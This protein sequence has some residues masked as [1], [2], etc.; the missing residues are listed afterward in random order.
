MYDSIL[1]Y[2]GYLIGQ[3]ADGCI[4]KPPIFSCKIDKYMNKKYISKLQFYNLYS[5]NEISVSKFINSKYSYKQYKNYFSLL[6]KNC[7][8]KFSD[9]NVIFSYNNNKNCFFYSDFYQ[10][11]DNYKSNQLFSISIYKYVPG[12]SLKEF[13]NIDKTI[14]LYKNNI[15]DYFKHSIEIFF[16][17]QKSLFILNNN[18]NYLHNDLHYNNII[19]NTTNNNLPVIIDFGR[20][21]Q[22]VKNNDV[23]YNKF[24]EYFNKYKFKPERTWDSFHVRFIFYIFKYESFQK[25]YDNINI[26][27]AENF[28][29]NKII[30][31]FIDIIISYDFEYYKYISDN[32]F[33]FFYIEK[34]YKKFLKQFFYIFT[35]KHKFLYINDVM[36]Y[37]Y[38]N[39]ILD[40]IDIYVVMFSFIDFLLFNYNKFLK[41]KEL[42]FFVDFFIKY[43]FTNIN[44]NFNTKILYIDHYKFFQYV[45]KI[46]KNSQN[47]QNLNSLQYQAFNKQIIAYFKNLNIDFYFFV[48]NDI[49]KIIYDN[50]DKF[51]FMFD[52]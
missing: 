13:F 39:C 50:R 21:F 51:V 33:D 30:D 37:I 4:H 12:F 8:L 6:V 19:I 18:L 23:F 20:S 46:L 3:G 26:L 17:L 28:L 40:S 25:Y 31:D 44:P 11:Y 24:V 22:V 35:D 9:L 49:F 5:K 36:L 15:F 48:Y 7:L 16:Y 43:L 42:S 45:Y 38:N 27:D 41:E 32:K 47:S 14:L 2:G 1:L 34:M 52:K 29:N 10:S